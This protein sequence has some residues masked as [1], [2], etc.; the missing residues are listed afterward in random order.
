MDVHANEKIE[1]ETT[2]I[3]FAVELLRWQPLRLVVA[4]HLRLNLEIRPNNMF[5]TFIVLGDHL[6]LGANVFEEQKWVSMQMKSYCK[7]N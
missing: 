3:L 1:T 5:I 6:I 2:K 4:S 7:L